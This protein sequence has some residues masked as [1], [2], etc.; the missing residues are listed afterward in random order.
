MTTQ[1]KRRSRGSGFTLME[2]LLVLA[3]LVILGSMVTYYFARIQKTA[4]EDAARTQIGMFEGPLDLYRMNV[5]SYPTTTQGLEAL[6]RPPADLAV[7]T[8]WR[9][10]YVQK[11]IPADPWG[12]P[13]QYELL[14]NDPTG[15]DVGSLPY[16][17]WCYGND[18]IEGT[19]D[20]VSNAQ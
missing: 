7:P 12:R 5:G 8:K 2:V 4:S 19:E 6:R 14:S 17:I 3:I 18:G 16:R 1:R 11:E 9:G 20:D 15:V 13:Y 10:P